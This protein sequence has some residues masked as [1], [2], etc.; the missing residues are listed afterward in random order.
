MRSY[1]PVLMQIN[2]NAFTVPVG[3]TFDLSGLLTGTTVNVLSGT[4]INFQG[5]DHIWDGNGAYWWDGKGGSAGRT[6]PQPMFSATLTG[7]MENIYLL[8]PPV[9]AFALQ[10][11]AKLTA[12]GLTV[13]SSDGTSGGLALNT[14]GFDCL[15]VNSATNLVFSDN[16][17]NGGHGISI[18]SIKTGAVVSGVTISNNVVTASAQGLRIKTYIDDTDASVSNV[19]YSGNTVTGCT[20]YGVII[21]QNYPD[22]VSAGGATNGIPITDVSFS[23]TLS[24]V[25]VASTAKQVVVLC[26]SDSCTGTWDWSKLATSG[27]SAGSITNAPIT[28]YTIGDGSAN[29]KRSLTVSESTIAAAIASLGSSTSAASIFVEA[30]TYSGSLYITYGGKLSIYGYTTDTTSYTSNVVTLTNAGSAA[31][32]GNDDASGTLRV[33]ANGFKLYNINVVNSYGVGSQALALSAYGTEQGYYGCSFKGS[34]DTVLTDTGTQIFSESYIEGAVDFIFGQ[35]ANTWLDHCTIASNAAGTITASGRPEGSST[36]IYV[37]NSCTIKQAASATS[38]LSGKVYLGRPWSE[39]AHAV[40]MFSSLSDIIAPA[41]W[42]EW[43][44]ASPNTADVLFAEYQN[45]GDGSSD[46]ARASFSKQL[47]STSVEA[48]T[49]SKILGSDYLDWIDTSY[50]Y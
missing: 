49:I 7:T 44:T 15:A 8:N 27:G 4:D 5:N 3:K 43:S 17:C 33:H 37:F 16:K 35:T 25:A 48:Y 34:Q 9:R 38:S 42:E 18:G 26:G 1:D 19:V 28:G 11:P 36:G 10:N 6:K 14:D 45:S 31:A 21:Q 32:D 2:I 20:S 50:S 29:A 46:S 24:T 12:S 39:Y 23:G 22:N 30:G 13:D 47:T 41:G 40:F